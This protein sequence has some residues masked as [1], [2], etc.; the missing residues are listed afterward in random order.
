MT[1]LLA[2]TPDQLASEL[3][4]LTERLTGLLNRETEL[5]EARRPDETESFQGEKTRLATLYRRE[6]TSIKANPSRIDD[7]ALET[8]QALKR[9][10]EVFTDALNANGRAVQTLS[11][12]TEG[13]VKAVADEVA[14]SRD[15]VA[16]YGPGATQMAARRNAEAP[17][18]AVNRQ[19]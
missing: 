1:T 3:T 11:T 19:A 5:F 8:R 6:I 2:D 14:K 10:T 18:I 16:G 4:R 12:L 17:S 9:A 7:A 13:V 15:Q